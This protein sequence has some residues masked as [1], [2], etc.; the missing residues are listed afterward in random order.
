[1]IQRIS[2]Q[3]WERARRRVAEQRIRI[4]KLPM[5]PS[6]ARS[7]IEVFLATSSR[8]DGS[9][10]VVEVHRPES[11]DVNVACSCKGGQRGLPCKH[12]ATVLERN[13]LFRVEESERLDAAA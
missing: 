11:G 4:S 10:Y 6:Y 5:D 8:E 3:Q 13:G 9:W 2:E 12:V 1:M 7:H